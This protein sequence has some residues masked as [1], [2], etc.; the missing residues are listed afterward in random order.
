MTT[1]TRC[2]KRFVALLALGLLVHNLTSAQVLEAPAMGL[3]IGYRAG[4]ADADPTPSPPRTHADERARQHTR[5]TASSALTRARTTQLATDV[6]VSIRGASEAGNAALMKFTH[7]LSG[8]N[9]E[10]AMRRVRLHPDVAW[11][12]PDMFVKQRQTVPNDTEFPFQWHL[13]IP[14]LGNPA[15][16]NLPNAWSLTTGNAVVVAVVDSGVRFDHPE[17]VSL[18]TVGPAARLLPG[19]DLVSEVDV[20]NDGN[21]RDPDA[22]DPGDWITAG[23][24]QTAL[25]DGCEVSDSSWHG[26]FIAGQIAAATNNLAGI[27]GINWGARILPVRVSGKCGALVSDLLDG[28]RWAAGLPVAGLPVNANP[29]RVINVSFG[30]DRA[31]SPA[32]QDTIN[33]ATD[34]GALVVVAAGNSAS[35][36]TRPADCQRVMAVAAVR[37][38]GAKTTYSSFGPQVALSAPGGSDEAGGVNLLL[39]TVNNGATTPGLNGFGYRQGTSFAAPQAVGVASLMLAVNDALTPLA[40]IERMK[41]AA[42]PHENVARGACALPSSGLCKC[43]TTTCG[44]GLLDAA[45]S[46]QIATGPAAI[47]SPLSTVSPGTEIALNGS[48]S[49]A[50]AGSQIA[51]YQWT[52]V[53]GPTVTIT[54]AQSAIARASLTIASSSYEFRLTVTDNFTPTARSGTDTVTVATA[55]PATSGGGGGGSTSV[56]WGIALWAWVVAVCWQQRPGRQKNS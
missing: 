19:Y 10:D 5:W 2:T 20:A 42:R 9:L 52:Q 3:I 32:Y 4:V 56:F 34:A 26:T 17:L 45:V 30:G 47:I 39:S 37:K 24:T 13:Q 18:G 6:G 12:E 8:Q 11:V 51:S 35:A 44:A 33:A 31:C 1:F 28:M 14:A 55:Y 48:A 40:L 53:G 15:A 25:F 41:L 46:L 49:F 54:N 43:T 38:D 29:A 7:P 36:L 27:A 50:L 16:M 21:G 22:S 23:D